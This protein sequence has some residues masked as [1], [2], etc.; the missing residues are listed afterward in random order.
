MSQPNPSPSRPVRAEPPPRP[1]VVLLVDDSRAHRRML[2][3]QLQR[4]GYEVIEA[5]DALAALHICKT[6]EPD[7]ILSDWV[8]AGLSGPELARAHRELPRRGYGYFVLLTSKSGSADIAEGLQSG[9][10]DFL[11]KPV[12]GAELLARLAAGERVI[13]MQERL[14]SAN[15]E[16]QKILTE[17]RRTQ[18]I[19][20]CDLREARKLQQGLIRE[21]QRRFGPYQA[22]LLMRPAG[23]I[24]GDLVG[25]RQ[26]SPE[27]V[28]LHAIDVSGHGVTSALVT[29]RLAAHLECVDGMPAG[30]V[31]VPVQVVQGLN[32]MMLDG[33]RTDVYLTM[34]YAQLHLP[35]G[36][37]RLVQAGHP[38]PMLQRADGSIERV[39]GGGLPVGVFAGASFDEVTVTLNGGDRIFIASDGITEAVSMRGQLL[40]DEGLRAI[41]Q[42]NAALAGTALLES[43]CWSVS[44]FSAGR[45]TDDVSAVLLENTGPAQL[46]SFGNNGQD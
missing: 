25:F 35:S 17:L 33:L 2:S 4:A 10:D 41:L 8:M 44:E 3:M 12:S 38:H 13:E 1:R 32:A 43:L 21:R 28:A 15:R 14:A 31:P 36:V 42:I 7:L 9:A 5:E 29:A 22:S 11:T 20:E 26:L 24:G 30:P 39:G 46:L 16:L 34:V 45:R 37:L 18:D 23:M 19:M 27:V 6:R 40:G